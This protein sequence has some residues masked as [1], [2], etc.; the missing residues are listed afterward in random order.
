MEL[1]NLSSSSPNSPRDSD[2]TLPA[3]IDNQK[4]DTDWRVSSL[5]S[6]SEE[7]EAEIYSKIEK[8]QDQSIESTRRAL[9]QLC[10]IRNLA[11]QNME[12]ISCQGG[13]NLFMWELGHRKW[14]SM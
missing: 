6:N 7:D 11:S 14:F 10:S 1:F 2:K 3:N 5:E 9:S 8:V 4:D 12:K 13:K